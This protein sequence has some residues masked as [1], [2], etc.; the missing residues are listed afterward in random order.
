MPKYYNKETMGPNS[1]P[2]NNLPALNACSGA[3]I[4]N[5][6]L[7]SNLTQ[8]QLYTVDQIRLAMEGKPADRYDSPNSTDIIARIPISRDFNSS[9][10]NIVYN[11][12]NDDADIRTY[13]G[14]VNL[15]KFRI[16]L[17][18]DKGLILNLNNMDWSFS[19]LVTQL[20]Q[21]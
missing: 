4:K 13:F 14:P 6:D 7:S 16:R 9:F 5:M 15:S 10:Q 1:C 11:N 21:Y 2:P 12:N 19:I 3:G 18:N 17:L 8:K 20:Y